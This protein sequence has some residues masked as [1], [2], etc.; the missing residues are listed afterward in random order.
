MRPSQTLVPRVA[1]ILRAQ[2]QLPPCIALSRRQWWNLTKKV[3]VEVSLPTFPTVIRL[4]N[5]PSAFPLVYLVNADPRRADEPRS[6]LHPDFLPIV[7]QHPPLHLLPFTPYQ[8]RPP[9]DPR[10]ERL[11]QHG[12]TRFHFATFT[13]TRITNTKPHDDSTQ[14]AESEGML[15]RFDSALLYHD[16]HSH[17]FVVFRKCA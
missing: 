16:G 13:T 12:L 11:P 5:H 7:P 3:D 2:P 14:R 10:V 17:I 6:T 15:I 9:T 8:R 1:S 4:S